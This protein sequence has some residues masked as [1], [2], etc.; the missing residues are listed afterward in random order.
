MFPD[1]D[2]LRRLH[3]ARRTL[4]RRPFGFNLRDVTTVQVGLVFEKDDELSPRCILLS[5]S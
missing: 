4:F 3:T 2:G 5:V 1:P